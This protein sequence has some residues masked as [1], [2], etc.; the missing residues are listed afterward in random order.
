VHGCYWVI[1]RLSLKC[2]SAEACASLSI[3]PLSVIHCFE[4]RQGKL[5]PWVLLRYFLAFELLLG[6][7]Y[8][9]HHRRIATQGIYHGTTANTY[10]QLFSPVTLAEGL[11]TAISVIRA[12]CKRT[13]RCTNFRVCNDHCKTHLEPAAQQPLDTAMNRYLIEGMLHLS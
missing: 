2:T 3:E 13:W 7:Q 11:L 12:P 10:R 6:M 1:R 4:R 9:E 5:V 8:I